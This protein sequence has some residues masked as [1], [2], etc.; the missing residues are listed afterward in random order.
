V[1]ALIVDLG[2]EYRGGQHQAL[3]LLQGL[4]ARGHDPELIA[5]QDSLLARRARDAGISVH[6]VHTGRRRLD[7][8]LQLRRL[9]RSQRVDVVQA[10]EP[11]ALTAT[12]LARAHRSVPVIAS[13][14]IALPLP[15]SSF[16][17][18]R[19]RAA[20]RIVA[21]SHFVEKSVI[22]SGLPSNC[23]EVIYDGVEIPHEISRADRDRTRAREKA[24]LTIPPESL[25]VGNVAAFVPE[26]GHAILLRAFVNLKARFPGCTLLL[27]GEGPERAHLKEL[28]RRLDILDAVKFAGPVSEIQKVFAAMNVFAFPSHDE[29]LGSALLAAMAQG[30]P[31]VA[32]GRGGI[33]EVVE[34]GKNGLLIDSLDPDTLAA[35]TTDLL[36]NPEEAHR[37]GK[38]ARETVLARFSSDRMVEATLQL[39][40]NVTGDR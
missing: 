25:C 32:I 5:T 9:V 7:A 37:L 33:P 14:R 36:A 28:A 29:P 24:D 3:L 15:P 18:A 1:R 16:S 19:Y 38:A 10:N 39:Y 30:L 6:A 34:N 17:L 26:K 4:L 13:R 20:T 31:V 27:C 8:A 2:R 35:A 11:H 21:V 22:D 40:E 12:W 23:V